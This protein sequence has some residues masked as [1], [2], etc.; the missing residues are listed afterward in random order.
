MDR[1]KFLLVFCF[2]FPSFLFGGGFRAG[3][4][5]GERSGTLL[6]QVP[7]YGTLF[8]Y[9]AISGIKQHEWH[10]ASKTSKHHKLSSVEDDIVLQF[11]H[12]GFIRGG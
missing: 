5:Y 12:R 3:K 4:R 10:T 1:W 8:S 2:L 7:L 11:L 9:C 6:L